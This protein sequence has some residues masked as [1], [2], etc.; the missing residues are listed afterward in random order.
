[1]PIDLDL[2]VGALLPER[3]FSWTAAD[4]LLYHLAIGAGRPSADEPLRHVYEGP[5]LAVIPSFAVVAPTFRDDALPQLDLPGCDLDLGAV[6]HYDQE[7]RLDAPI[8]LNGSGILRSRV[9]DVYDARG[10]AL[11]VREGRASDREGRPLWTVRDTIYV[12]GEVAGQGRQRPVGDVSAPGR[13]ADQLRL[14]VIEDTQA[15]LYR[16]CGDRNPLHID[17]VFARAAGLDGPIL[18]GLC[19]YGIA[20]REAVDAV[21]G[22]DVSLV[23]SFGAR[24]AGVVYPGEVVRVSMWAAGQGYVVTADVVDE[25]GSV[26]RP[27]LSRGRLS[28]RRAT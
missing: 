13:P 6:L 18:H 9:V 5:D 23:Q 2:A 12:R 4:V 3:E 21:L 14:A 10:A 25:R 28:V 26:I 11:I 15:M 27:A 22:G 7:V 20:L 1:M 17:P 24:F 8:A 16:L 19:T